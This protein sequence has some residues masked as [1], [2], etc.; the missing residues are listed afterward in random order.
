[1]PALLTE[2][3][4][5]RRSSAQRAYGRFGR[6][7]LDRIARGARVWKYRALSDCR[8]VSGSPSVLQPV[9]YA[10]TGRIEIGEGVRFGWRDSPD[11]YTG[12]C[13]IEVAGPGALVRIGD[14]VEFSNSVMVKSEGAGVEIGREA[15]IGSFVEIFDSD[16]HDLHPE[17]RRGGAPRMAPVAIGENVFLGMGVRVLK[18][19]TIG[20]DSVIGAG[21]VVVSDIPA[22]VV[23]A[24][25]PARVIKEL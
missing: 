8:R 6:P 21:S 18:G 23:A 1:M 20:R 4:E 24:G 17:R 10:G 14:G 15:L 13:H 5:V 9:L 2:S 3:E 12:Y 7:S 25:S 11:F 22:G 16:F 19:V